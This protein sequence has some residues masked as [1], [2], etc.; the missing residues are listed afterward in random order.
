MN[1]PALPHAKIVTRRSGAAY[2]AEER[3]RK[4]LAAKY[5]VTH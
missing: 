5:R 2:A 4:T 1:N 3:L